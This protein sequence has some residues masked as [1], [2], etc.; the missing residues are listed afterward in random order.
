MNYK[1]YLSTKFKPKEEGSGIIAIEPDDYSDSE[2]KNIKEKEYKPLLAYLSIG[3]LE[4]ER[5]W[6]EKY[7]KLRLQRLEDWPNEWYVDVSDPKWQKFILNRAKDLISRGFDGFWCD[8]LDVYEYNKKQ[9][10]FD[11]CKKILKELK[12]L[13]YV[14]VNGGSEFFDKCMDKKVKLVNYVNGVTQE[15]VFSLIKD[16][17]GK[18]KFGSQELEQ[19]K[20]YRAYMKRL[21]KN[22]VQ[23]F[24]LEYT[25]SDTVKKKIKNWCKKYKM[26]GYYISGGVNL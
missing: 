2:I 24:L 26:T 13:G 1:V 8:N 20:W 6:F 21:L 11:G 15:E 17:S 4:K 7:K 14:M 3:T 12:K 16:Y 23:T 19:S 5:S 25:R 18:G 22:G 10:I 9:E